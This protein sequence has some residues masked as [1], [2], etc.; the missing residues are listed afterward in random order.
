MSDTPPQDPADKPSS[1][2]TTAMS[3]EDLAGLLAS[4]GMMPT[5]GAGAGDPTGKGSLRRKLLIAVVI[6]AIG[7]GASIMS[8]VGQSFSYRQAR[9]MEGIEQQLKEIRANCPA[10]TL[11]PRGEAR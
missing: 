6:A 1:T 7:V 11:Q 4:S 9:A 10:S 8:C 2:P 3:P 5:P